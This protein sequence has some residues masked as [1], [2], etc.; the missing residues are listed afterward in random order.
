MIR[1][2]EGNKMKKVLLATTALVAF[3]G[4]A[5]ADVSF[6]GFGRFGVLYMEGTAGTDASDDWTAADE[7]NTAAQEALDAAVEAWDADDVTTTD[8]LVGAMVAADAAAADLE[9]LADEAAVDAV[10][11]ATTLESR[12][13]LY[14]NGST[15][16]DN[17][18]TFGAKIGIR[19]DE[20]GAASTQAVFNSPRFSVASGGLEIGAG[21]IYGALDSMP[22]VYAGSVGLS[23]LGFSN[24]V[25]NFA[26]Q[27]YADG[28]NGNNGVELI[29]SMDSLT[30][31][32]SSV[33][34]ADTEVA[35]AYSMGDFS[36]AAGFSNTDVATNAEMVLTAGAKMGDANI[37][38]AFA[39]TVAGD[40]SMTLSGSFKVGAATTVTA[41]VASDEAQA[42]E[43]AYGIGVVHGLGGGASLRG[44][45]ASTHGR[46][47]ADFGVA[48]SF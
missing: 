33:K 27:A 11:D 6:S 46:T 14:I 20:A 29:Y 22:G 12:Y 30:V 28:A 34:D 45:F 39:Q 13:N 8:D 7:A 44:G 41:Y 23:G 2:S 16:G 5:S 32:V 18:L 15:E 43:S 9:A 37:G 10:A 35:V 38:L 47:R 36:V 42:D 17:G 40:N 31:H 3:A 24:V 19:S 48:F 26:T 25:T 4:A 1:N 21:N